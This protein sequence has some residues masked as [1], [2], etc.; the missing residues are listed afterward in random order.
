MR[1]KIATVLEGQHI[2]APVMRHGQFPGHSGGHRPLEPVAPAEAL[3]NKIAFQ[4]AEM[5]Q[6]SGDNH[7]LAASHGAL[8]QELFAIQ[9]E[10]QR[11]KAHMRSIQTE[12]NIQIRILHDK[13]AKREADIRDGEVTKKDL[14]QAH[15]EAQNLVASRQKLSVQIE[16]ARQKLEK[17]RADVKNLPDLLAERDSLRKEYQR[18]R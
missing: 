4:A 1:A 16:Q 17:A 12:S 9:E 6:L 3:E 18:L 8:R 10:I 14:Q 13:I 15:K 2:Q 5:E 11:L 7:R